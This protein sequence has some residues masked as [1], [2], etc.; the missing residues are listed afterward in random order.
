MCWQSHTCQNCVIFVTGVTVGNYRTNLSGTDL[1]RVYADPSRKL[2]PTVFALKALLK[3]FMEER[4]V[5]QVYKL[6]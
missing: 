4:E 5:C 3:S 1:N 2:H 6:L